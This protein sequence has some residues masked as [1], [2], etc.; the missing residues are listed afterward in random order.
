MPNNSETQSS[1]QTQPLKNIPIKEINENRAANN[2]PHM[3]LALN[4]YSFIHI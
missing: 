2:M 4:S 1:T 3:G